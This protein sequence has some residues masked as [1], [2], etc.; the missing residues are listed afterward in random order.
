MGRPPYVLYGKR[1]T[2][3]KSAT[4]AVKGLQRQ[5]G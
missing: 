4:G 3:S 2:L 1:L 5:F